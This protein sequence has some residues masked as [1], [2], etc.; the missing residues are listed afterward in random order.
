MYM[1]AHT[2][3]YT[4]TIG[5]VGKKRNRYWKTEKGRL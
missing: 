1:D 3:L 2:N 5:V 4:S